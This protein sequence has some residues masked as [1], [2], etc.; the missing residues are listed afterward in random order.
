MMSVDTGVETSP[1]SYVDCGVGFHPHRF[2]LTSRAAKRWMRPINSGVKQ[3]AE[4]H[5]GIVLQ[6]LFDASSTLNASQDR[7]V[8]KLRV[9]VDH[10][11]LFERL[12]LDNDV[13]QRRHMGA[14]KFDAVSFAEALVI[15]FRFVCTAVF[16]F[17]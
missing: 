2:S 1:S 14:C 7:D 8:R 6:H 12:A 5:L 16:D 13:P 9:R 3:I 10:L 11:Q 17:T 15:Y 4:H